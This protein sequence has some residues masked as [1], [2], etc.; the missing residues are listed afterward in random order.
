MATTK[1]KDV[2][3]DIDLKKAPVGSLPYL[4]IGDVD[5]HTKKY[6]LKS[7]VSVSGAV[8]CPKDV[9][10]VSKVRPSRG[11]VSLTESEIVVSSA[12]TLLKVDASKCLPEY[13]F[14]YL[15]WNQ[16]FFS[17]LSSKATGV[18]YPTVKEI[19]ILNYSIKKLP[20]LKEQGRIVAL[21]KEAEDLKSKRIK[22][23]QKIESFVPALFSKM[24]NSEILPLVS[25]GE[26]A[27][28]KIGP[29]GTQLHASDYVENAVPLVNPTHIINGKIYTDQKLTVQQNKVH[30]LHQYI[31]R[32]GD[33]VLGRRGEMGRCALVTNKEDGYL[34]GT[35]SLF[36]T[37]N[38]K[39]NS[40][41]LNTIL[42]SKEIKKQLE[43]NARGV[44]MK[45]LNIRVV[46]NIK[47]HLPPIELQNKFAEL[48]KEIEIQKEK[49]IKSTQMVDDLFNAV[50]AKSF[51]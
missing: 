30:D 16:D 3:Q 19:E 24:L 8:F 13:L 39:I 25:L 28:V 27:N 46:E 48:V 33:V 43:E 49:Q 22:A 44:T 45:N 31:M 40:L 29:F 26:V 10:I 42:S 51:A 41:V 17:Y 14:Y 21:V 32:T 2:I 35:G 1:I 34:C 9:V 36:L 11:A 50:M 4:E 38:K 6:E 12:F 47:I 37:P 18:T 20:S 5:I 7:K 15:A 23:N